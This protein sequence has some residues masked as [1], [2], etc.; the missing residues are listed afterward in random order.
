MSIC[1]LGLDCPTPA[2]PKAVLR[3]FAQAFTRCT[4]ARDRLN[5][6]AA[7]LTDDDMDNPTPTVAARMEKLEDSFGSQLIPLGIAQDR[8][9]EAM[10]HRGAEVDGRGVRADGRL[11]LIVRDEATDRASIVISKIAD[12]IDLD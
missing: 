11:F 12:A 2:N 6:Y 3:A 4:A 8:A 7:S 5:A 1:K 9:I 10:I